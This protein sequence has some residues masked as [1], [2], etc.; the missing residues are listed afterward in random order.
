MMQSKVTMLFGKGIATLVLVRNSQGRVKVSEAK[1]KMLS[2]IEVNSWPRSSVSCSVNTTHCIS[3]PST[4]T[5][6][7]GKG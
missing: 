2:V 3:G 7:M 4:I 5:H 1:R 6:I